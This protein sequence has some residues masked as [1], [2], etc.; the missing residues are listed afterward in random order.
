MRKSTRKPTGKRP[1]GKEE[2]HINIPEIEMFSRLDDAAA[3]QDFHS[4]LQKEFWKEERRTQ[5]S[6]V[7]SSRNLY[8]R[9]RRRTCGI[10]IITEASSLD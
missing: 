7:T 3:K 1:G 2:P 6:D 5:L 4:Q 10:K 9:K 8:T